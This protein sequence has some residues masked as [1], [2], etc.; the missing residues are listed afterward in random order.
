MSPQFIKSASRT[1]LLTFIL[2]LFLVP[3]V[4]LAATFTVSTEEE[5]H[6]AISFANDESMYPGKD[7]ITFAANIDI[8]TPDSQLPYFQLITSEIVFEGNGHSLNTN[9]MDYVSTLVFGVEAQGSLTLNGLTLNTSGESTYIT[10]VSN[11]GI[12]NIS[13]S[14][15][16]G[17]QDV[18]IINYGTLTIHNVVITQGGI[19]IINYGTASAVKL[20]VSY[21]MAGIG[22][23][24]IFTI[25]DSWLHHNETY[26]GVAV[27]S[28]LG[29][30]SIINSLIENNKG[31]EMYG[32]DIIRNGDGELTI[33]NSQFRNNLSSSDLVSNDNYEPDH[34]PHLILTSNLFIDNETHT[35]VGVWSGSVDVIG[36]TIKGNKGYATI[37]VGADMFEPTPKAT[38]SNT[39]FVQNTIQRFEDHSGIILNAGDTTIQNSTFA[40]NTSDTLGS[41][42]YNVGKLRVKHST[43]FGNHTSNPNGANIYNGQ[44][45]YVDQPTFGDLTIT[46]SI[47]T[48]QNPCKNDGGTLQ[49]NNNLATGGVCG[50]TPVTN[51]DPLLKDNG[52]STFTH[53]LLPGSNAIDAVAC[54]DG[55]T[56]D[57]RGVARPQGAMC[58][59]G[60]FEF[61]APPNTATPIP[62]TATSTSVLTQTAIPTATH[63]AVVVLTETPVASQTLANTST[64]ATH[65]A[66]VV[67]TETPIASATVANTA[68]TAPALTQTALPTATDTTLPV[69]TEAPS[70]TLANNST[71]A[72][73]LTQTDIPTATDT[74]VMVLTETPLAPTATISTPTA[75]PSSDA[76]TNG[77][78]ETGLAPWV[79]KRGLGDK[80]KCNQA[81]KPPVTTMGSCAFVFKGGIGEN[82][83]LEQ[84][85]SLN[86]LTLSQ[87]ETLGLSAWVKATNS[88]ASGKIKV[89]VKYS[90]GTETGKIDVS[91]GQSAEYTELKG[92]YTLESA[93]VSKIKVQINHR[94]SAG[95]VY[96][97][98][99]RLSLG[100]TLLML[101]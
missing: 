31:I 58:D 96:V 65:T 47:I 20:E 86:G 42:I 17:F 22:N 101:P 8:S 12:L 23:G 34:T 64:T 68:T 67:L 10:A 80:V 44:M 59:I 40:Q 54:A 11:S 27:F 77:G 70:A 63:T 45:P 60:A 29:T 89:R 55:V 62:P 52:G 97:D 39:I 91:I 33:I 83:K 35:I 57:Q 100:S 56:S 46:H 1:L 94:S 38:I 69:L 14:T 92:S 6:Y 82:S 30:A 53:A 3:Q 88:A 51:L 85:A 16:S 13:D 87:G 76:I 99:V 48:D 98:D 95:K 81:G 18:A 26:E 24:G 4:T 36:S 41:T 37:I 79:V 90:D 7:I 66:V 28:N 19:P 2:T 32:G 72:P 93:N 75:S 21:R 73:V 84:T 9:A 5:L 25:E 15:F 74:A 49:A 43:F 78:F 71:T 61:V 50:T